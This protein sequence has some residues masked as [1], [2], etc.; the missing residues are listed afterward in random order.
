[1][2]E[3]NLHVAPDQFEWEY[4]VLQADQVNAFCL[5]GGKICV[6]TGLLGLV[7]KRRSTSGGA[8]A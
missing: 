7:P 4:S 2:R 8:L 1:M 6:F 3:I 5:P